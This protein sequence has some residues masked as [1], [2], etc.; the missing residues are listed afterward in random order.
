M[1]VGSSQNGPMTRD[2]GEPDKFRLRPGVRERPATEV[3]VYRFDLGLLR[4]MC[5]WTKADSMHKSSA[6]ETTELENAD[7]DLQLASGILASETCFVDGRS[8]GIAMLDTEGKIRNSQCADER[9]AG[10]SA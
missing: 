2:L 10:R 9:F 8:I 1:T 5:I 6:S 3:R 7:T 4:H